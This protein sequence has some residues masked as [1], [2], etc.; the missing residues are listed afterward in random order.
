V[1][2]SRSFWVLQSWLGC[3]LLVEEV[4]WR[5]LLWRRGVSY[6]VGGKRAFE[7]FEVFMDGE[8]VMILGSYG[9]SRRYEHQCKDNKAHG[10]RRGWYENNILA[11]DW[12][13]R[14][15]KK[16]GIHRGWDEDGTLAYET[17]WINGREWS[18]PVVT[19][20]VDI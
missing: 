16:H 3:A 18:G 6:V 14:D 15:G 13:C 17:E 10:V 1:I 4:L 7:G 8:L 19:Y 9:R 2:P 11:Y 5:R 12:P 20:C